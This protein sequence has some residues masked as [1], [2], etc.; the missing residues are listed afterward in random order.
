MYVFLKYRRFFKMLTNLRLLFVFYDNN[1]AKVSTS[2][3]NPAKI[4]TKL[5]GQAQESIWQEKKAANKPAGS[6]VCRL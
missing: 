3:T 2:V 5:S 4:R 6:I 1:G